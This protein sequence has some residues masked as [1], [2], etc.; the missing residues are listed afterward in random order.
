MIVYFYNNE[1]ENYNS[2]QIYADIFKDNPY[3][4]SKDESI[5]FYRLKKNKKLYILSD[6]N[7]NILDKI[8]K[9]VLVLE[10]PQKLDVYSILS[11]FSL[12]E[13]SYG[14]R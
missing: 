13:E 10:D 14:I 12:I 7:M 1:W 2:M 5:V 8:E 6:L 9:R 3:K 4:V 11:K